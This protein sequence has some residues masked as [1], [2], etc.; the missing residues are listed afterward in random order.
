MKKYVFLIVKLFIMKTLRNK[1]MLKDS[2]SLV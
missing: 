2:L 1:V